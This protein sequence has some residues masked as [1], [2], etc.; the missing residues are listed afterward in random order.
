MAVS[1]FSNQ[2]NWVRLIL[3]DP[4]SRNLL[5]FLLLNLSFAFVE[6]FCGV[7]NN[8][9]G[10]ISDSFHM[11]FDCSALV[12][13]LVASVIAK[14][15]PNKKYSYGFG[16]VEV[17]SGYV[18]SMFLMV[19]GLMLVK[20]AIYRLVSPPEVHTHHLLSVSV[21]GLIVNIIGLASF[22]HAHSHGGEPCPSQSQSHS[23]GH[24]HDDDD[25]H[26]H[27]HQHTHSHGHSHSTNAK[28]ENMHGVYL[29]ILADLLGSVGVIVSSLLVKHYSW[30]RADPFCTL[31]IAIMIIASVF[32]LFKSSAE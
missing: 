30:H 3:A 13:G 29:H 4:N 8:S 17:L 18:N 32:P 5:C 22:S 14:W 26:G 7:W 19:I 6:L 9:L 24:S 23:H 28:N 2:S 11:F 21:V 1:F 31:I 25:S 20:E 27:S 10:L 16:R 12:M 15:K